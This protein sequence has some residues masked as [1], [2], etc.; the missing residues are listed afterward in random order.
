MSDWDTFWFW[1]IWQAIE[2]QRV[3]QETCD[4]SD[5]RKIFRFSENFH[6]FGKMS[7][8]R[9]IIIFSKNFQI[10]ENFSDFQKLFRF[11]EN[12]QIFG[13]FS[14]FL[15]S[16]R[17]SEKFQIIWKVSDFL[18]STN[19]SVP[20]TESKAKW[21]AEWFPEEKVI[22]LP[23][24]T[25]VSGGEVSNMDRE[26]PPLAYFINGWDGIGSLLYSPLC[27]SNNKGKGT[28]LL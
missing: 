25:K 18:K 17:F 15:K 27:G 22:C 5:F 11:S 10:F 19:F 8:F 14:D 9:K 16:F 20:K 12:F 26:R 21:E 3:T 1:N 7:Y 6:I 4:L 28:V 13:K 24:L 23:D 2:W